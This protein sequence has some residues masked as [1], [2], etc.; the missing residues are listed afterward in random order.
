MSVCDLS[1]RGFG[2]GSKGG[3]PMWQLRIV[4]KLIYALQI[5]LVE[6][7]TGHMLE[8]KW[9]RNMVGKLT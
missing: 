3:R 2:L 8:I 6:R 1:K 7:I 4:L 9:L 5:T